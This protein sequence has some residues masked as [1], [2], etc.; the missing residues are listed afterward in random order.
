[1]IIIEKILFWSLVTSIMLF[2]VHKVDF[3]NLVDE[4]EDTSTWD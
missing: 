4:Y 1:M 2:V 3:D